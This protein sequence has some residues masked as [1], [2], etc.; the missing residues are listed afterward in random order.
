MGQ[1]SAIERLPP[2]VRELIGTLCR[3]HGRTIDEIKAHLRQLENPVEV[4]R[5]AL[6]RYTKKISDQVERFQA[7]RML[8]EAMARSVQDQS[9]SQVARGNVEI[10]HSMISMALRQ[11]AESGKVDPGKLMATAV[12]LEKA[13]AAPGKMVETLKKVEDRAREKALAEAKKVAGAAMRRNGVSEDALK[14]IE[15]ELGASL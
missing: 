9:D 12:A 5:S 8:A 11:M 7:E 2:E 3:D 1:R 15:A 4:S 10:M 13:I 14:R 6:G